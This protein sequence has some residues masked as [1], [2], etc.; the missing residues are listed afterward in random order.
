ME[1][2][3]RL[4]QEITVDACRKEWATLTNDYGKCV[5]QHEEY[6]KTAEKYNSERLG[7]KVSVDRQLKKVKALKGI[8][9]KKANEEGTK[10]LLMEISEREK[11]LENLKQYL[12]KKNGYYLALIVGQ[13][14][15]ILDSVKEKHS[16]KDEYEKFKFYC[17]ITM[18][19]Y[20][21]VLYFFINH[22]VSDAIFSYL[23][24]WYYCT[25]TVRENILIQN[26]SR[27]KG[28]YFMHHYVTIGLSAIYVLWSDQQSYQEFRPYFMA[29]SVYQSLVQLMQCQY[30][31]GCLYR[32]RALGER[33]QDMDITTEG[34]YSWMWKGL[35]FLLPFLFFGQFW[36]FYNSFVLFNIAWKQNFVVWHVPALGFLF[37]VLFFFNFLTLIMVVLQKLKSRKQERR[38]EKTQ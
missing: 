8:L 7:C 30:Q 17:S 32:L 34:F 14:N 1:V 29:F 38:E 37:F 4:G 27:I 11:S 28:W 16:Y 24:L 31:Q 3:Q 26:G 9:K 2:A 23:L 5:V 10:E 19:I 12:P 6:R 15:M 33:H 21:S 35:A 13:M 36:Q 18:L 22:R 20:S 25:L